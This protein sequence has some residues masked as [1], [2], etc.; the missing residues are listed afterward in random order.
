MNSSQIVSTALLIIV[1]VLLMVVA[2]KTRAH[3]KKLNEEELRI[4]NY[5]LAVAAAIFCV[6]ALACHVYFYYFK[7]IKLNFSVAVVFICLLFSFKTI[8]QNKRKA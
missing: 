1:F 7:G 6:F 8:Y 5:K 2:I 4:L 3:K